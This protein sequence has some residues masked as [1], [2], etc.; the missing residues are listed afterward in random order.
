VLDEGNGTRQILGDPQAPVRSM[1]PGV[2]DEVN[3]PGRHPVEPTCLTEPRWSHP[4]L[5]IPFPSVG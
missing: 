3:G 4:L 1:L 2:V 5:P